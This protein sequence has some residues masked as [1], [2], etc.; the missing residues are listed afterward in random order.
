MEF[1]FGRLHRQIG[2]LHQSDLDCATGAC[3][4]RRRPLD[5]VGEGGV[6]FGQ[7]GLEHDAGRDARELCFGEDPLERRHREFKIT[8]LLHVEV[9]EGPV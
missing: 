1:G 3:E 7:V 9:D 4:T 2:A 5:E 8:V 6:G